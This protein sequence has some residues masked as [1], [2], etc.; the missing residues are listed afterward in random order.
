MAILDRLDD[1]LMTPGEP[2]SGAGLRRAWIENPD[3]LALLT[4]G[5]RDPRAAGAQLAHDHAQGGG[6]LLSGPLWSVA[7]GRYPR[8]DG[9]SSPGVPLLPASGSAGLSTRMKRLASALVYLPAGVASL[10]LSVLLVPDYAGTETVR[11]ALALRPLSATNRD[12]LPPGVT[13]SEYT[14]GH[15][16]RL[17]GETL[18]GALP[19]RVYSVTVSDLSRL[20]SPRAG[21]VAELVAYQTAGQT[22]AKRIYLCAVT[23]RALD[24]AGPRPPRASDRAPSPVAGVSVTPGSVVTAALLL[25]AGRAQDGASVSVLG[26]A[27]GYQGETLDRR[28][29]WSQS[30]SAPHRHTGTSLDRGGVLVSDGAR[31]PRVLAA[32][33]FTSSLRD[34]ATPVLT[35]SLPGRGLALHPTGDLAGAWTTLSLR[36]SIP[37]GATALRLRLLLQ[38][39][40][41]AGGRTLYLLAHLGDLAP[42]ASADDVSATESLLAALDGSSLT[43][44]DLDVPAAQGYRACPLLPDDA[45]GY[46]ATGQAAGADWSR[47]ARVPA[48]QVP[49]GVLLDHSARPSREVTLAL[50]P[51]ATGD[52]VLRLR[53]VLYLGVGEVA[54]DVVPG[55]A[56]AAVLVYDP[57][58]A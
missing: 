23:A 40:E 11:L 46:R 37:E 29:P 4:Y 28:R 30:L 34:D 10:T 55:A 26:A 36:V 17:D 47:T 49:P 18:D 5:D 21:R 8:G 52:Y 7:Y 41:T 43:D 38:P 58:E 22:S 9:S 3:A 42:L 32:A 57:G 1:S 20:G 15:L 56:L 12:D 27:P 35:D 51:H 39:S 54:A 25:R 44:G 50:A 24:A 16:A 45:P 19:W 6:V 2:V 53:A 33:S 31:G 14:Q 48:A 13:T